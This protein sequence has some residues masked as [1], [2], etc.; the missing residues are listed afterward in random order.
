LLVLTAVI[1]PCLC[2][3]GKWYAAKEEDVES[4]VLGE[5]GAAGIEENRGRDGEEVID[6]PSDS[7]GRGGRAGGGG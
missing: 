7:V 1:L 5:S 6:P 4:R 3:S 2:D